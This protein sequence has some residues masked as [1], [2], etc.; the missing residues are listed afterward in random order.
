[1]A[2]VADDERVVRG[3]IGGEE[4]TLPAR[5]RQPV[6]PADPTTRLKVIIEI[7]VDVF[8]EPPGVGGWQYVHDAKFHAKVHEAAQRIDRASS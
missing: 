4:W 3:E 5:K 2:T 7:L 8:A 1:M 6:R